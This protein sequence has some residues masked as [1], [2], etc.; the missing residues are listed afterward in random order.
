MSNSRVRSVYVNKIDADGAYHSRVDCFVNSFSA[1]YN[2]VS[3]LMLLSGEAGG[4]LDDSR[5]EKYSGRI[6]KGRH[7]VFCE[8]GS[9]T[10]TIN[11][12]H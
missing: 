3:Y 6:H 5:R 8:F 12:K 2:L 9:D 4:L 11:L 10:Y 7:C 1:E